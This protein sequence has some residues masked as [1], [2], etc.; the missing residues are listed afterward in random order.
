MGA[1]FKAKSIWDGIIEKIERRLAKWKMMYLSSGEL[2]IT[3]QKKKKNGGN[4]SM[5]VGCLGGFDKGY[6]VLG[7]FDGENCCNGF[8]EFF[9]FYFFEQH[10][11]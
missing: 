6:Y 11:A 9:I 3:Y 2:V 8:S 10:Q 1:S 4:G 7:G 5:W